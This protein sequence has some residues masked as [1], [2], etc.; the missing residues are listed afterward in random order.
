ME[1]LATYQKVLGDIIESY[2]AGKK[3]LTPE[4]EW[5]AIIDHNH[6][7]YQLLS[8]GWHKSRYVFSVAFHFSLKAGKVWIMQNNTDRMIADELVEKGIAKHDI[9]LGF[10]PA[11]A[12]EASG[13]AVS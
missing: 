9:V 12:R 5:Q 10:V 8:V 13:F 3:S 1:K 4:V 2:A 11:S 7:Q 6:G